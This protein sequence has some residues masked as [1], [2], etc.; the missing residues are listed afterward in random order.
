MKEDKVYYYGSSMGRSMLII[1]GTSLF[2]GVIL[3]YLILRDLTVSIALL[4]E[5][6]KMTLL[7]LVFIGMGIKWISSGYLQ[8]RKVTN[9]NLLL[10]LTSDEII[11]YERG[12]RLKWRDIDDVIY[13]GYRNKHGIGVKMKNKELLFNQLSLH[14]RLSNRL[15]GL[16]LFDA[17]SGEYVQGDGRAVYQEIK[18]YYEKVRG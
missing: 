13:I 17:L 7:L 18:E 15:F 1:G 4:V 8:L 14:S 5:F 10:R 11:N 3:G 6:W 2:F 16:S 9:R 12:I